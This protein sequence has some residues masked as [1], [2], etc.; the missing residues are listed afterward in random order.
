MESTAALQEVIKSKIEETAKEF[1]QIMSRSNCIGYSF[2]NQK[3][4]ID[5]NDIDFKST[6]GP[7]LTD[8][9]KQYK[10]DTIKY[11]FWKSNEATIKGVEQDEL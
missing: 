8:E 6:I 7:N 4:S 11:R 1:A 10:S 9:M 2:H 5:G 3:I